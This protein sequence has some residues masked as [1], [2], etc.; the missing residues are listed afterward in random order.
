[1]FTVTSSVIKQ[2]LTVAHMVFRTAKVRGGVA[3]SGGEVY[4]PIIP[5]LTSSRRQ[6]REGLSYFTHTSPKHELESKLLISPVITIQLNILPSVT[7]FKKFG[8]DT[9]GELLSL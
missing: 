5:M 2:I 3:G 6:V 1:M 4:G 7:P 8:V 9:P